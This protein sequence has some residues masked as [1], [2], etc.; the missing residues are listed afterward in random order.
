[1][2]KSRKITVKF[3]LNQTVKPIKE[4]NSLT[5]PLYMLLTYNR[6]STMLKCHYG[7]YYKDLKSIEKV[8]YPGFQLFE[9][10][11]ITKTI[12]HEISRQGEKFD[13]KGIGQKYEK[14]C[15]GIDV[16]FENYMKERLKSFIIR[17]EPF[18]YSIPIDWQNKKVSFDTLFDMASKLY[19]D[20]EKHTP[21]IFQDELEAYI[22][23]MKLYHSS[24][25]QYNFP[26]IIEWLDKSSIED[27]KAKL[28]LIYKKNEKRIKESIALI[29]RIV[30]SELE[31]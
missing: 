31:K 3:F 11:I 27:Y 22:V 2:T 6:R 29:D 17:L 7:K 16:L 13:I 1:M 30:N 8:H 20:I 10:R 25:Y 24:F 9:E 14:Y 4:G 12:Q 19:A 15:V 21:K 23:F 28:G 5:Y 26:T 18:E